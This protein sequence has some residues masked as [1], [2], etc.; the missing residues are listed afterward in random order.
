MIR[1]RI[2]RSSL[3]PPLSMGFF[4]QLTFQKK[5][6]HRSGGWA[7]TLSEVLQCLGVLIFWIV[8]AIV[9][10]ATLLKDKSAGVRFHYYGDVFT[11]RSTFLAPFAKKS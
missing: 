7:P 5:G 4:L 1:V 2:P 6:P 8:I 10:H 3:P 11:L 9:H